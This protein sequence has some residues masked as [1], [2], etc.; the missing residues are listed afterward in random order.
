M[1]PASAS[2]TSWFEERT[3]RSCRR[4]RAV[5]AVLPT[6]WRK[7]QAGGKGSA[8][9]AV[10]VYFQNLPV[11]GGEVETRADLFRR[12]RS[13]AFGGAWLPRSDRG[14]ADEDSRA[15]L[16][17]T[18]ASRSSAGDNKPCILSQRHQGR[19]RDTTAAD[20]ASQPRLWPRGLAYGC[21]NRR[22]LQS[23][24][25]GMRLSLAGSGR[26]TGSHR[27][28]SDGLHGYGLPGTTTSMTSR[29]VRRRFDRHRRRLNAVT[30]APTAT[31]A[32][33]LAATAGVCGPTVSARPVSA[34]LGSNNS[35]DSPDVF[36]SSDQRLSTGSASQ[37]AMGNGF[38]RG[39]GAGPRAERSKQS[40]QCRLED[41]VSRRS[42]SVSLCPARSGKRDVRPRRRRTARDR[43]IHSAGLVIWLLRQSTQRTTLCAL[44]K[45]CQGRMASNLPERTSESAAF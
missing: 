31:F 19:L 18:A 26:C 39:F 35:G 11:G 17:A 2:V 27:L 23:A 8:C 22:R 14:G 32:A 38:G 1:T 28:K 40:A 42:R 37:L 16:I 9:F 6:P 34:R 44:L 3:A 5:D 7:R 4:R 12:R 41:L 36:I 33:S 13:G 43:S 20:R 25:A 10:R 45:E 30:L 15:S 21:L 29:P 24:L